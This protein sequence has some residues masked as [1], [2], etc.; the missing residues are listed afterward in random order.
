MKWPRGDCH[1]PEP[2]PQKVRITVDEVK[3][4]LAGDPFAYAASKLKR[5]TRH[6]RCTH[7]FLQLLEEDFEIPPYALINAFMGM[8]AEPQKSAI[9]LCAWAVRQDEPAKA[10]VAWARRNGRGT[11][12]PDPA[13]NGEDH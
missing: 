8:P 12:R 3:S 4:T 2:G 10:L 6:I 5:S 11:F 1:L 7:E 9:K 13:D